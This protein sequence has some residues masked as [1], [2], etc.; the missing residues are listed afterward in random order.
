MKKILL[1]TLLLLAAVV[2]TF[3]Q[4]LIKDLFPGQTGSMSTS[5]LTTYVDFNGSKHFFAN[6]GRDAN[7]FGEYG[8]HKLEGTNIERVVD[9]DHA[10][11][12]QYAVVGNILYYTSSPINDP[13]T[14][15]YSFD[16]TTTK[17][18]YVDPTDS[19]ATIYNLTSYNNEVYFTTLDIS[20]TNANGLF[21]YDG[22]TITRITTGLSTFVRYD[23][24][25]YFKQPQ[26]VKGMPP[27]TKVE[28]WK[29]D[30][31]GLNRVTDIGTPTLEV[32]RVFAA[33]DDYL[34][35][36][37][38]NAGASELWK[39]DGTTA[40]KIGDVPTLGSTSPSPT[41]NGLL[42][43]DYQD[44][45]NKLYY[46]DGETV[47]TLTP[48]ALGFGL[49]SYSGYDKYV[50]SSL[51]DK[52]YF[53]QGI[54]TNYI[55]NVYAV[56]LASKQI[57]T[58]FKG[59]QIYPPLHI[60]DNG[61]LLLGQRTDNN[62][63]LLWTIKNN[64]SYLLSDTIGKKWN[65]NFWNITTVGDTAIFSTNLDT[66]DFLGSELYKMSINPV[67]QTNSST[68]TI[69]HHEVTVYPNPSDTYIRIKSDSPLK[70]IVVLDVRG[71]VKMIS[72]SETATL[73]IAELPSGIYTLQISTSK[74][75]GYA[76]F[77][78]K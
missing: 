25:L 65:R 3:G 55:K 18:H 39:Y 68:A 58:L 77:I 1:T 8:L 46:T 56:D 4:T 2:F 23:N 11:F 54:T 60:A 74:G 76:K 21:S 42:F 57:D 43:I 71:Q 69:L 64:K 30:A 67:T 36:L 9:T 53:I 44:G 62:T 70:K 10:G 12:S 6:I 51:D 75:I 15:L 5:P 47:D 29:Y 72:T 19:L 48:S 24:A 41:E 40:A 13:N 73:E 63:H 26:A 61:Q 32:E 33:T 28:V 20:G 37:V 7:G 31:T 16:G 59:E 66:K 22:S 50:Y 78:K 14:H 35:F 52:A 34:T 38:N 49:G 45:K 17:R 27:Y